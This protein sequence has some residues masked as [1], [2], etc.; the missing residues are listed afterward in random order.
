MGY[1]FYQPSMPCLPMWKSIPN[2]LW[3][4]DGVGSGEVLHSQTSIQINTNLLVSLIGKLAAVKRF[5]GL[6]I[7]EIQ[8][9]GLADL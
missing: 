3:I 1:A 2:F 6:R 7:E 9:I 8:I 4:D 5:L